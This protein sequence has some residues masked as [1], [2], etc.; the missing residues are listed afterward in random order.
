MKLTEFPDEIKH[1]STKLQEEMEVRDTLYSQ[2]KEKDIEIER[3][4]QVLDPK[5]VKNE[6]QRDIARF[7]FRDEDYANLIEVIAE[8][9]SNIAKLK[10][11]IQFLRDKFAVAKLELQDQIS[12]HY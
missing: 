7:D 8:V 9:E 5:V 3:R 1:F 6:N 11:H 10:I 2:K 4:V 12:S